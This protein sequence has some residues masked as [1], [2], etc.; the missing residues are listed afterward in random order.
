MQARDI[1]TRTVHTATSETTVHDIA[2]LMVEKQISAVPIVD[3]AGALLGIVSDGDLLHRYETGTER[4]HSRWLDF[5]A[6]PAA[7]AREFQ[8]SHGLRA[9]DVMTREVVSVTP[10]TDAAEIADLF[11]KRRIKRVPVVEDQ[12]LVGIIG[13]RDLIG[14]LARSGR[15]PQPGRISDSE[16]QATLSREVSANP[17]I[18]AVAVN[19]TVDH[20][21][22]ELSGFIVDQARRDALRVLVENV[23]GIGSVKDNL[24]VRPARYSVS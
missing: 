17:W 19:I 12:R 2:R 10:D 13:P 18:D 22:V 1:M 24:V 21:I 6:D 4:R 5:F 14:A 23:A 15:M 20:G 16:I 9:G 7:K 8:K 3:A 11:E